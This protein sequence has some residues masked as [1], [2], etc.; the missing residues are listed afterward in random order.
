LTV[1]T[2]NR[3]M[4]IEDSKP[5]HTAERKTA[6]FAKTPRPARVLGAKLGGF[7]VSEFPALHNVREGGEY[8]TCNIAGN[9]PAPSVWGVLSL[10][11][12]RILKS[13]SKVYVIHGDKIMSNNIVLKVQPAQL[14]SLH[15]E[16]I[17]TTSFKIAEAFGKQHKDVLKAIEALDCSEEY[18]ERNFAL[19]FKE[20][21]IGNG[22]KRKSKYYQI[23]KDGFYFLVMGFTGK[24]A[25]AWKEAFINAFNTMAKQL[26]K[27]ATQMLA[28]LQARV[29]HLETHAKKV[30]PDHIEHLR[31]AVK[32]FCKS[33]HLH[34]ANVYGNVFRRFGIERLEEL[35]L[36]D[37]PAACYM[38]G[39]TPVVFDEYPVPD[40]VS[41]DEQNLRSLL[42][43]VKRQAQA[44]DAF[45][46]LEEVIIQAMVKLTEIKKAF[47]TPAKEAQL[48]ANLIN[49]RSLN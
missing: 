9:K 34:H 12:A 30:E 13:A 35:K 10:P 41:V 17:T 8:K 22:A 11:N 20:V 29:N 16:Q 36:A 27:D 42:K 46:E 38:L 5:H 32:A 28:E 33:N 18:H 24:K 3:I 1:E 25:A 6:N 37:Y 39:E 45:Y 15:N 7:C 48:F 19:M 43:M 14:V 21:E 2:K 40:T 47:Y 49:K 31:E 4:A 44:V 23:T 26:N